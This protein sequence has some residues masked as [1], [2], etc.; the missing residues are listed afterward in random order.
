MPTKVTPVEL[1]PANYNQYEDIDVTSYVNAGNTSGVFLEIINTTTTDKNFRIRKNG[2]TD[3]YVDVVQGSTGPNGYHKYVWIGVDSSDIFEI[4]LPASTVKC[5]LLG[6]LETSEAVF[7][8]NA[9]NLSNTSNNVWQDKDISSY[10]GTDTAIAAFV[11]IY[12]N[13]TSGIIGGLRRNGSTDGTSLATRTL[14]TVETT[15]HVINVDANEI[16]E[17]YTQ[18]YTEMTFRLIG[19][20]KDNIFGWT[21]RKDYSVSVT[22]SYQDMNFQSD[23]LRGNNGVFLYLRNSSTSPYPIAIREK[24]DTY[25]SYYYNYYAM[26]CWV[27]LDADR[28]AEQKIGSTNFDVFAIGYSWSVGG[29]TIAEVKNISEFSLGSIKQIN[30]INVASIRT[31][32]ERN[33]IV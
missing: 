7:F 20:M 16:F 2:S 31:F 29:G 23:V 14:M 22:G 8:D 18:A 19:Y 3:D 13:Y 1:V 26:G 15:H 21:N 10:T 27:G 33:V 32:S 24:G 25:D 5:Y 9:I 6:Y 28:Y 30:G 4:Y 17:A 11:M 12:N